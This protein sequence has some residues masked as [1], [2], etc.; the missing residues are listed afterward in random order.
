VK[1]LAESFLLGADPMK[2]EKLWSTMFREGFWAQGGGSIAFAGI[3]STF[4][5][6][7]WEIKGKAMGHSFINCSAVRGS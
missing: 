5:I 1:K 3:M 4:D 6:A 2:T 7:L